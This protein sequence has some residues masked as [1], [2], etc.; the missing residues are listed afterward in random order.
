MIDSQET[1]IVR[2]IIVNRINHLSHDRK[3]LTARKTIR[4][5]LELENVKQV[6]GSIHTAFIPETFLLMRF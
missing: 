4:L 6:Y 3:Y 1:L 5:K 2:R